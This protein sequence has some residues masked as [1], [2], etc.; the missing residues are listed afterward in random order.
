[1]NNFDWKKCVIYTRV[2]SKTQIQ[3]GNGLQSQEALCKEWARNHNVEVVECFSD[4]GI[5]GKFDSREGLDNMIDF[6][7]AQN[8]FFINIDFVLADDLDRISRD[9]AG[10][11][12]IKNKIE[13]E[14]KAWIQTV[15]QT[16]SNSAE[17]IFNQN[18]IM[19][20]KQ[21]ERENNARR[22]KD[23]KRWR[24]IDWYWVF[25][26]PSG[27]KYEWKW[28]LKKV[29][30]TEDSKHIQKALELYANWWFKNDVAFWYYLNDKMPHFAIKTA[31][32]L[33]KKE[34]LLFYAGLITYPKYWID[35]VQ[36]K[37]QPIISVD[38]V[39][40]IQ[41][42]KGKKVFYKT[43]SK[44]NINENLPLRHYLIC[45][46]CKRAYSWWP[47]YNKN[48]NIYYYYRCINPN[49]SNNGS[50][51]AQLVHYEFWEFLKTLTI[52]ESALTCFKIIL[53]ELFNSEKKFLIHKGNQNK[54]EIQELDEQINKLETSISESN[55]SLFQEMY[56]KKITE[57]RQRKTLLLKNRNSDIS[58]QKSELNEMLNF[59]LPIIKAPYNLWSS[60]DL[61]IMQLVPGVVINSHFLYSKKV[62]FTTPKD[63]SL[64]AT[65]NSIFWS[66]NPSLE[67]R[68]IELRSK[69]HT[70]PVLP[71]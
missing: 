11:I 25:P 67:V 53:E 51:N 1:M 18:I 63:A 31:E 68:R 59:V 42:R 35:S 65:F 4:W 36:W 39:V 7:I 15:K 28:A 2:S 45:P 41:N 22:V 26:A 21:Y 64:Y 48:N 33:L 6:L 38:T 23:R 50:L 69:R 60:N 57:L 20:V 27:Y 17:W 14:G 52:K 29:V 70:H 62:A 12:S 30:P 10:W 9:V 47:S 34:R 32:K 13:K 56:Q 19:A 61:K 71:L 5:S 3:Q 37:H 46:E 24:M 49:C 66:K 54:E 8:H 43:A 44:E 55:D 58:Y 40:K 16:I